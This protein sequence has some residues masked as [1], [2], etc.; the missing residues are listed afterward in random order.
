MTCFD[1]FLNF[2]LPQ[3]TFVIT[4]YY[5]LS[6]LSG[7]FFCVQV[8]N[9]LVDTNV[10]RVAADGFYII[11][12]DY[13]E[14]MSVKMHVNYRVGIRLTHNNLSRDFC[15]PLHNFKSYSWCCFIT[16]A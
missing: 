10:G 8:L 16:Y 12:A 6:F 11:M 2:D 5:N 1:F 13:E 14:V 7:V 4:D 15:F 9:L 3:L